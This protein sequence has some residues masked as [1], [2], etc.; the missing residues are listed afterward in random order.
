MYFCDLW[1]WSRLCYDSSTWYV[2]D[3][4]SVYRVGGKLLKAVKRFYVDSLPC[5]R[6]G[7]DVSEWLSVNVGLRQ[8]CGKSPWLFNGCGAKDE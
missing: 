1:I 8:C 6:V 7:V 4:T 3:A 2:A 5:V